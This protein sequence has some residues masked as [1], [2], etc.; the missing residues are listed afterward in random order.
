[1]CITDQVKDRL[2][3]RMDAWKDSGFQENP[4]TLT[5]EFS[6]LAIASSEQE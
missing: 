1:M 3:P 4:E 6:K 2:Y 5:G